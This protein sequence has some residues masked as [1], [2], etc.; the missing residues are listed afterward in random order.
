MRFKQFYL[1]R[2]ARASY[3]IGSGARRPSSIRSAT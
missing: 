2:L 1:G 3:M